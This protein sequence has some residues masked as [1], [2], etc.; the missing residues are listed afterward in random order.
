MRGAMKAAVVLFSG[1]FLLMTS[2]ELPAPWITVFSDDFNRADS[3]T[4]GNEWST[5]APS[6][7]PPPS[8]SIS[9]NALLM[10]G[11]GPP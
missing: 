2:C 4:V 9:G 1:L 10:A 5:L 6:G 8:V 3:L 11:A 7:S